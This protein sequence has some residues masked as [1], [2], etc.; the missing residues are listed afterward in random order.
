MI[1]LIQRLLESDIA[2]LAEYT[3]QW[4]ENFH[5]SL[6]IIIYILL[7]DTNTN[8][9]LLLKKKNYRITKYGYDDE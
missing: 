2:D 3:L 1:S 5:S 7:S 6:S 4:L 9:C 8:C